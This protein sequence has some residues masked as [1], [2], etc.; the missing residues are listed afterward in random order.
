M[1]VIIKL[2]SKFDDS[3][4]K[5][6][7]SGFGGL[8]KTLGAIGIGFGLK[9]L[10]DGLLDAAKAAAADEKSTRLLNIQLTRN[11]GAT[12]ASLKENDKFIESLSLQTGIMDDDLR[13]A[14]ARFGNVTGNVKQAQKLLKISLDGSAGSGKNIETVSKAVAKAYGGNTTAL[15]KMFPELTK[16]KDVLGDF[17][18]T[19]EGLA[20]ENADPFM[21]FNNSMDIL[22]EKLGTVVLPILLDFIDEISKPGGAIEVVGKF[23]DDVA[24][25]KTD[26][27]QTFVEIKDAVGEVIEAVKTF[28]GYFGNG[29][30]VEGFK[31]IATSLIN[32]LPALLA[33]KGIFMLANAGKTVAN[34]VTAMTAISAKSAVPTGDGGPFGWFGK[35]GPKMAK[36][37]KFAGPLATVAT[38]LSLSGD[39]K[40]ETPEEKEKRLAKSKID[41]ENL[42]KNAGKIPGLISTGIPGTS[43]TDIFSPKPTTQNNVTNNITINA[44]NVDP[45]VL[46]DGLGKYVKQ[47]GS[48]PS[49]AVPGKKP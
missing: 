29:D 37:L 22:K 38:V 3:G 47:N 43:K 44:P 46:V 33:L 28:F 48:L 12:A 2:L 32:M 13:P 35:L 41:K 25:P 45:K 15:K 34:L 42:K 11:A 8:S 36:F 16:S 18:K 17:A 4:L 40:Q 14:M 21:K 39:T 9:Q 5:K 24:N 30:A 49:W 23:F 26:V 19:Y 20:E 6:A 1:S 27:G 7:K 31:N 10:T